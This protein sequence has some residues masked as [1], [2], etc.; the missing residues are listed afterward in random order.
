[1]VFLFSLSAVMLTLCQ[2]PAGV[3]VLGWVA[4]VP[5]ILACRQDVSLRKL[6]FASYI[7]GSI[8]WLGNVYWVSYVALPGYVVMGFYLGVYW[9][10]A[11]ALFRF[12]RQKGIRFFIAAPVIIAGLEA[13]QGYILTGFSWRLLGHSQ[14]NNLLMIQI[15]DIFGAAG[16][17]FLAAMVNGLIA[18]LIARPWRGR[19]FTWNV[20]SVCIVTALV[21]LTMVYG[22]KALMQANEYAAPGPMI[23]AA[24]PNIPSNVKEL[25]ENG[26]EIL[27][28]LIEK[29]SNIFQ[30]GAVLSVWP[31]TIVLASM[32]KSYLELCAPMSPPRVYHRLISQHVSE[33]G[34]YTLFGA[35]A[36]EMSYEDGDYEIKDRYNSAYLYLPDGQQASE[37][38]DKIHLVPF[39]EYIPL[40]DSVPLVSRL[41][42][43][44]SPYDYDY[45]LTAGREHTGFELSVDANVPK[46][47]RL[48]ADQIPVIKKIYKFGVLICYEDTDSEVTRHMA[49]NHNQG[50]K[51]NWLVNISNDGW[52][53]RYEDGKVLPSAELSQRT[54]I[55][56]F[57]AI[58]NRTTIV[59]SVNS[60]ISCLIEPSGRIRDGFAAGNLPERAFDRQG[61][62]GWFADRVILDQRVTFFTRHGCFINKICGTLTGIL[63]VFFLFGC[64]NANKRRK[65]AAGG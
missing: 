3:G 61:V 25:S 51:R 48:E 40:R 45:H 11:A 8:Y 62:D 63:L 32:N 27:R 31:E 2:A 7:A 46:G 53:V 1:M 16:V 15:A 19:S 44:L 65:N 14:Y 59:R 13:W 43:M 24:Q 42:R 52:Y 17:S 36:V 29:S 18:D 6:L 37:R 30:S 4:F 33:Y 39:G 55:S 35:H 22:R 26:P 34:R 41:I 10:V 60:G 28:G 23:G 20:A 64:F 57:R 49:Y 9:P 12:C 58:E 38:Y 56:V 47:P 5:F 21:G 54:A 50:V